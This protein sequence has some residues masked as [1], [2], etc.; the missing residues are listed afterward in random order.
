ME[1]RYIQH[2][3]KDVSV[4]VSSDSKY[5]KVTKERSGEVQSSA[6]A[7]GFSPLFSIQNGSKIRPVSDPVD[8]RGPVLRK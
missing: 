4:L 3:N 7:S 8:T 5:S 1:R 2:T 6:G